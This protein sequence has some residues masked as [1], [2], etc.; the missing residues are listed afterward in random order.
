MNL[1]AA[2]KSFR[3]AFNKVR[4]KEYKSN[5]SN[6]T[7]IGKTFEDIVGVAE[8]NKKE[9]DWHN[10]IEIK[11]QRGKTSSMLTLF[12]ITPDSENSIK[13]LKENYGSPD[14][15]F[16]DVTTLRTTISGKKFNS[17]KKKYG[18]ILEVDELKK[19][20]YIHVRDHNSKELIEKKAAQFSFDSLKKALKSKCSCVAYVSADTR[21]NSNMEYFTFTN[22]KFLEGI[23]FK[24]FIDGIKTGKIKYDLRMGSYKSGDKIGQPHDHG[25]A[26]RVVKKNILEFFPIQEDI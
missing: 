21:K 2:K 22:G 15:E 14:S 19:R 3:Y 25:S 5:R 1:Q 23:T 8:N 13:K 9:K 10:L 6:N 7:G 17:Y 20:V 4:D 11:S 24:N 26:F 16:P 18:F 12:C